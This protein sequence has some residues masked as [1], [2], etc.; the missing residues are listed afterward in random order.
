MGGLLAARVLAESFNQVSIV[1]RDALVGVDRPRRGV[2][3]ARHAHALLARGQQILEELFPGLQQELI[4]AGIPAGD[5]AGNLRWYFNGRRLAQGR[6]DLLSVSATRPQLEAA[7]RARV[8]QLPNVDFM[9]RFSINGLVTGA[10][11]QI[12]GVRVQS[13]DF[14][15]AAT[16]DA[17]LV[18]DSTGRGSRTPVWLDELG[19][20]RP[21]EDKVKV[22]LAY[23]TRHFRLKDDPYGTDLSINPV[24]S[25]ANPRGAFFPKL[26]DGSSQLSLT[27]ILGDH[28]PTD[29]EGFMAF[30]KTLAAP[31]I[32]EAIQD[33]EPL[34][35]PVTFKFPASVR[36]R[37]ELMRRFPAGLLVLGD[38]VCSFNPV[39]GQGMTVAAL[40]AWTLRNMLAH[41]SVPDARRYFREIARIVDV[42]WTISAGADLGFPGVEGDRNFQVRMG[43][44]Y[45]ARLHAAAVK[46]PTVTAAFF[47]VAG[48]VDPPTALMRPALMRRVLGAPK[49]AAA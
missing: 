12:T 46:D 47:R 49:H 9:E 1:D 25:P 24:A 38:A 22:D 35:D 26:A 4:G 30:A 14:G 41:G 8:A 29:A 7:V 11:G 33:A 20:G 5:I 15:I 3:H 40:E 18:V 17:D 37:Y 43:N 13:D 6:A 16:L 42:S 44:A 39:Y 2:P 28:P 10:G 36:R 27:G 34:D 32:F 21:A 31:E 19:F 45:M 48:L 23:T